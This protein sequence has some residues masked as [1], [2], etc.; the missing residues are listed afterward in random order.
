MAWEPILIKYMAWE[1]ILIKSMAWVPINLITNLF[2]TMGGGQV[3]IFS[4]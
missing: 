4:S 3:A 2:V 1:P